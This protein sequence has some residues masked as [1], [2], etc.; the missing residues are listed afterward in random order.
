MTEPHTGLSRVVIIGAGQAGGE[1]AA[2]LR[3][4]G[5]AGSITILGNE[6]HLP[7]SRPLL[8]KG[9]CSGHV[10]LKDLYIRPAAFYDENSI[11]VMAGVNVAAV[12]REAHEV[13]LEDGTTVPYDKLVLATGGR[14]RRLPI[15]LVNSAPNA[16]YIRTIHDVDSLKERLAEGGHLV[17]LGGG[18]V[19]LEVASAARAR[20]LEVTLVEAAPRLLAR[21]TSLEVSEFLLRTHASEG[22]DVRVGS[23]VAHFEVSARGLIDAIVLD[24]GDRIATDAVVVG[25]GMVANDELASGAGLRVDNGIVVDE[26]CRTDDPDIYAVGDCTRHPDLTKGGLR[27]LESVPNAS[28]Q[29]RIVAQGLLGRP[30]VYDSVPWFWSD[31]Y[32]IKLQVIGLSSGHDRCVI[33]GNPK[34]DK[35][36]CAFYLKDGKVQAADVIGSP[37]DFAM[38]KRLVLGHVQV[39]PDDLADLSRSL[40]EIA[41]QVG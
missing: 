24:S 35:S 33:R 6:T 5:F 27:R 31:Q 34:T 25:I 23:Q 12:R 36:F 9:Y 28:E 18:Y 3:A 41:Q 26:Y 30:K 16:M 39:Q 13:V 21:V 38:A 29:A 4:D 15:D 7:Y 37:R 22:V 10:E 11:T 40:K 20:G 2:A 1:C 19:G 14:P 32:D 8:S 17:V